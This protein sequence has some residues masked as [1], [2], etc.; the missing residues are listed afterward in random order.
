MLL[1]IIF[2]IVDVPIPDKTIIPLLSKFKSLNQNKTVKV[3][4]D[5]QAAWIVIGWLTD[6]ITNE[7]D[8]A[9]LQVIDSIL[10]SGMSS[11]LFT[12]L[13]DDKGL[14]YQVGSS[15]S[16][17][18][19]K[20]VFAVYIGTNPENV[21]VAKEGLFNEINLMKKEFVTDKELAE[22]KDKITGNFILSLETNMDK[23]SVINAL[24]TDGRGYMFLNRYQNLINSVTVKDV[25]KAA[26]KYFSQPYVYTM[27]APEN[28]TE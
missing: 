8:W 3:K 13:R 18:V 4:K 10:G 26:N 22:A 12:R 14:A 2:K 28:V 15:F 27:V 16:A 17:N 23:A 19:N 6:G 1:S 11:R 24:E 7:K 20:G 25:I 5:V 21:K 9:T